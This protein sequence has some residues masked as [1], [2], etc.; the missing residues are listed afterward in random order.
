[1][2]SALKPLASVSVLSPLASTVAT[3]AADA[4]IQKNFGSGATGLIISDMRIL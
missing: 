1:M 2:K 3:S 4:A